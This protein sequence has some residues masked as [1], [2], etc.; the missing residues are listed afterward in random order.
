MSEGMVVRILESRGKVLVALLAFLLLTGTSA[1]GAEPPSDV[2]KLTLANGDF[3]AGRLID[4]EQP[5]VIRWQAEGFVAPF[6]FAQRDVVSL[7]LA[8]PGERQ[9]PTGDYSFEMASGDLLF[10]KLVGLSEETVELELPLFGR[11]QLARSSLRRIRR[12]GDAADLLYLGP[13]GLADWDLS[14]PTDAWQEE[15]GHLITGQDGAFIQKDFK[16]PA[17]AVIEFEISWKSTPNFALALGVEG[18]NLAVG[19]T[20]SFRF[21]VWQNHLVAMRETDDEADVASVGHVEKGPG[22]M[23]LVAYLDQ[24]RH[25]LFVA[26]PDGNKLA[27]LHVAGGLNFNYPVIR[28]TNHRGDVRLERLR[29]SRWKGDEPRELQADKARLHKANGSIVYGDLKSF[30]SASAQFEIADN[31]GATRVAAADVGSIVLNAEEMAGQSVRAVLLDGTRLSGQLAGVRDGKLLLSYP[32]VAEPLAIPVT[33]L[34]L[35]HSLDA[36][37]TIAPREGRSGQLEMTDV[38]LTGVLMPGKETPDASG[39]VWQPHASATAS[40]LVPGTAGRI[41]YREPSPPQRMVTPKPAQPVNRLVRPL[42]A[43]FGPFNSDQRNAPANAPIRRA[44]HL[45]TGD[46][47]P[48]E[49]IAINAQG[50]TF[51][52]ETTEATLVPHDKMK[53]V[54]LSNIQIYVSLDAA[55]RER[56]LTLPRMQRNNPPTHLIRFFNGDYLRAKIESMDEEF[57]TAEIRLESKQFK[58]SDI[59]EIIWLHEDELSGEPAATEQPSPA[60]TH[61]QAVRRDGTRL[62]LHPEA[63]DGVLLTGIS[64]VLGRCHVELAAVDLLLMGK[65][66]D[67]A[68]ARLAYGRWRLQHAIDPKWVSADGTTA[69]PRGTESEMVGKP[70]P[71]FTLQLLDGTIFQLSRQRG[72]VV[73]L[74]FW[75]TWC[76][77]C[78]QAMPQVDQVA[79]EF[80]DLDVELIA[81]NLQETPDKIKS[82]LERLKLDP[83]VVLDIDGVVADRYSATSIPQTV[84]IDRDGNVARLFVGADPDFAEQLRVALQ[85]VV[86]GEDSAA[87][88]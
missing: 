56:L 5:H 65:Q 55:K 28:L 69:R 72:K 25:R 74:D 45:R 61:V 31:D 66:V 49:V 67:D 19:G 79:R 22:R 62:T 33:E 53:A 12:W 7:H 57:L 26:S 71:D 35:L 46:T 32:S 17:Q 54:E 75:A 52:S 77:P 14:S 58:R 41:V 83:A 43:L 44:L 16:L 37:L 63:C 78:I 2:S 48:C 40:A 47:I 29:I 60:P 70:A 9:V 68:A 38:K 42:P 85:G 84:I 21:E 34:H 39:L 4:S 76:G 59:Y 80:Q 10:G 6:E 24:Q 64:D 81:V 30:D 8:S 23:H 86:G 87:A 15:S 3:T 50:V 27:D 36:Q 51:K 20:Q 1:E 13:N 11:T 73:I 88:E 18:G 82:T